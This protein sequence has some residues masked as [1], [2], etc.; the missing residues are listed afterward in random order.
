MRGGAC[1]ICKRMRKLW[2]IKILV[3]AT[4]G[5]ETKN[6]NKILYLCK[7]CLSQIIKLGV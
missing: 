2:R 3:E 7:D 4:P 6:I 1:P 5:G